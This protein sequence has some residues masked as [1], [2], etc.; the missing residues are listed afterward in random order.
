MSC[1]LAAAVGDGEQGTDLQS[2]IGLGVDASDASI[3]GH[4]A[5]ADQDISLVGRL[6]THDLAGDD[7]VDRVIRHH[8]HLVGLAGC[9][10]AFG[11]VHVDLEDRDEH[12]ND[13]ERQEGDGE[14]VVPTRVVVDLGSRGGV[15]GVRRLGHGPSFS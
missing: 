2:A 3:L 7:A 14:Q 1:G 4:V 9:D 13:D 11:R 10:G 15:L 5:E 12:P 8:H 6:A